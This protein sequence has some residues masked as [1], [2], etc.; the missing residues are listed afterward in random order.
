VDGNLPA[1]DDSLGAKAIVI[2]VSRIE[3]VSITLR[4][5]IAPGGATW[6]RLPLPNASTAQMRQHTLDRGGRLA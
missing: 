4:G 3:I 2:V 6:M 5:A 1:G